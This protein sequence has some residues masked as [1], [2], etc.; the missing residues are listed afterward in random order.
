[1]RLSILVPTHRRPFQAQQLL[2]SIAGQDFPKED[3]QVLLVSNL[4]DKKLRKAV[5]YWEKIF[6]DFKYLETGLKGVNKARN[7]GIRFAR[8]DII[9]FLDDD[10]LLQNKGHLKL[11]VAEHEKSAIGIGGGYKSLE[12]SHGMEKFYQDNTDQWIKSSSVLKDQSAQLVGGNASYKREVFDKGFY[13]DSSIVF[14]GSEESFNRSLRAQGWTLLFMDK[15]SVLHKVR[16]SWPAFIKKSFKQ[17]MGSAKSHT[18]EEGYSLKDKW[19]FTHSENLSS[20]SLLYSVFFKLGFFWGLSQL[21][22]QGFL[23]RFFKFI[24]LFLKSRW[25]FFKEYFAKWLYGKLLWPM[26]SLLL[27]KP[28]GFVWY[29]VGWLYGKLLWPMYSLLLLKPLGFVWYGVGWLYG[30]LLWPMYSLLL[31]KPLGFVWYGVG[32]LY[33]KLL[34]PMY[35]LLLLKPLGFVWYGVGWLYGKLL[36]PMYSLL[37]LKPLGFVWYGVGW[38]YGKLLWPMYSLLLL[39][40]LGFVWYGVGWLYGKLL[41]PM[42]S[43]LLLKPLGF[44]WYGV[45]WLYGKLLWPMYSLLLLKPLGFV[46]YGVGWLYGKLL[47]PMYSLLLLK[48]LGFVWYGVG[49]LY[50]KLLWP[51]YSLLLLKPLGFVWYGVGWLY[52]KLLWPMYSLLL[53]KPLGVM[54]YGMGW[55]YGK[56]I[57]FLFH[58]SPPM[59]LYYFSEYQYHKRIKPLLHKK[60]KR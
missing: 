7:L 6:F 1:M 44:V 13:F 28:L 58:H 32:W 36:W 40:P 17:G 19:A 33:G 31:L 57:L 52:G 51:M 5:S 12:N 15:L 2:K 10:C 9:Y 39:K 26:Y 29:G 46:W 27:L 59:K 14:G 38:L 48:P 24:F 4:K 11:L 50:G 41:W 56:V 25:Y 45:G 55:F 60:S 34:W 42:Y 21:G 20:Y 47:W 3:L 16:L 18:R 8:G 23:M 22:K 37:L 54:W 49:W 30:K 53:L 43:L 35:S